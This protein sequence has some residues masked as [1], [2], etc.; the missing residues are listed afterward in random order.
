MQPPKQ[1]VYGDDARKAMLTGIEKVA[2]AVQVTLGPKGRNVVLNRWCVNPIVTKDGITVAKDIRLENM[3]EDMGAQLVTSVASNT[4]NT[5]G[6][7]TTTATILAASLARQGM[8]CV[9]QGGNPVL[10]KRGMD[11]AVEAVVKEIKKTARPIKSRSDIER[12]A[13]I[14]GNEP[15]VGKHVADALEAVGNDG[16]VLLENGGRETTITKVEGMEFDKGYELHVYINN[17]FKQLCEFENPL[18][19]LVP[20]KI[21]DANDLVPLLEHVLLKEKRPLVIISEEV[22]GDAL[23]LMVMNRVQ[24]GLPVATVKAPGYGAHREGILEDIAVLLG[25]QILDW[26]KGSKLADL[27]AEWLGTCE[28]IIIGPSSTKII[29]GAGS[30]DAIMGRVNELKTLREET[31]N[32]FDKD[33]YQERIS[34]LIG[35]VAI[36]SVG[37]ASEAELIEKKYRYEDSLNA[38]RAAISEGIVPGGGVTLLRASKALRTLHASNPDER[39]GVEIVRRS[40]SAPLRQI[41]NNAGLSADEIEGRVRRSRDK[42]FGF[43]A[44]NEKFGDMFKMGIIDPA[45]VTTKALENAASIASTVLTAEALITDIERPQPNPISAGARA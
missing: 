29:N 24:G 8:R 25:A 42:H 27:K 33:K 12:V 7:G 39:M 32:E 13:T 16:V 17:Q 40:L 6:D 37:A 30:K 3:F 31:A 35:G 11:K 45:R 1:L 38:T 21:M 14:S 5:A 19:A 9:S 41:V 20:Y 26:R 28:R 43:D 22:L 15:L 44:L 23:D 34:K 2:D 10:V 36:I 4:N 18:I